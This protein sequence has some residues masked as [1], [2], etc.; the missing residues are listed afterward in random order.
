MSLIVCPEC[1]KEISNK[2]VVCINCGS[3]ITSNELVSKIRINLQENEENG[4]LE[5]ERFHN[6]KVNF[7]NFNQTKIM[8][9][10]TIIALCLSALSLYICFII[11]YNYDKVMQDVSALHSNYLS[12]DHRINS[13]EN[14]V[15]NISEI[16]NKV[17]NLQSKFTSFENDNNYIKKQ[18]LLHTYALEFTEGLVTDK[19]VVQKATFYLVDYFSSDIIFNCTLDIRAQPV[20]ASK[21]LGRGNFDLSDREL[22]VMLKELIDEMYEFGNFKNIPSEDDIVDMVPNLVRITANNYDVAEYIDGQII[23]AGE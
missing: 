13:A 8:L 22:R 15:S 7:W 23:L 11:K 17:N 14:R 16:E 5:E 3:P 12:I 20:Y 4:S 9:S 18:L 2:A 6:N 19:V 10:I 1:G 21:F